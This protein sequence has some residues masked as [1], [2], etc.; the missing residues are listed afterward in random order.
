[1][2]SKKSIPILL[3]ALGL[4]LMLA[5]GLLLANNIREDREAGQAAADAVAALESLSL[6]Q[7]VQ[8]TETTA[9]AETVP[10]TDPTDPPTLSSEILEGHEYV[11]YLSFP[12]LDRKLPIIKIKYL[13]D[14]QVAPCLEQG[15][16][17]T[18]DAVISAHNYPS[19]FGP[20]R[21]WVGGEEVLFQDLEGREIRYAVA[22]VETIDPSETDK[23]LRSEHDLIL[24][25]CTPGGAKRVV[26]A[27]DR[28]EAAPEETA[29]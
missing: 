28:A 6:E 5:A 21:D 29:A 13:E 7:S 4:L 19:H 3:V 8:A 17:W 23:V 14:L 18:N 24:Y 15:S 11:G 22:S 2:K 27:C 26:I 12:S 25:T 1:M 9:A 10:A 20:I 16:P